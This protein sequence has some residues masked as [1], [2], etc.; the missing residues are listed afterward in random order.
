MSARLGPIHVEFWQAVGV[1]EKLMHQLY[2]SWIKGF[3]KAINSN[4]KHH[5]DVTDEYYDDIFAL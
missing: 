2:S 5:R 3:I 4:I 1:S